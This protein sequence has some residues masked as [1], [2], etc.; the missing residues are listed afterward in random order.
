M[1]QS[2]STPHITPR[3][4]KQEC[5]SNN[6]SAILHQHLGSEVHASLITSNYSHKSK[7]AL[8]SN[9]K[10]TVLDAT[11]LAPRLSRNTTVSRESDKHL[12]AAAADRTF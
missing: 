1:W 10:Q 11:G 6:E 8:K 9:E 4:H 5:F 2:D 12:P 3:L 7:D